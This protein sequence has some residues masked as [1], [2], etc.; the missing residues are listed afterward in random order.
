MRALGGVIFAGVLMLEGCAVVA[1]GVVAGA[2]AGVTYT[3]MGVGEQTFNNDFDSV[4]TALQKALASLDIKTG[5]TRRTEEGGRI[6]KAEIEAFARDLTIQITVERVSDQATR[7]VV[8]AGKYYVVKDK[9][10]AS[11]ILSQ[12]SDNLDKKT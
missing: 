11:Q 5:H 6:V 9:A 3:M 7:V 10:I 12:T 1:V 4:T 2:A 8:D